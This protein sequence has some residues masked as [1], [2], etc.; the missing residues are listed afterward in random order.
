MLKISFTIPPNSKLLNA[1]RELMKE[2][3]EEEYLQ[4]LKKYEK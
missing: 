4:E 3:S 2:E 1:S